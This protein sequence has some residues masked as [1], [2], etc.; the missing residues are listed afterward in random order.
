MKLYRILTSIL[1][2]VVLGAPSLVAGAG[3]VF[4]P[5]VLPESL[6]PPTLPASRPVVLVDAAA[7][8]ELRQLSDGAEVQLQVPVPDGS[9]LT[10]IVRRHRV[11]TE[12]TIIRAVTDQGIVTVPAPQS[13]HLKGTVAGHPG[14]FAMLSIFSGYAVGTISM[15]QGAEPTYH[16]SPLTTTLPSPIAVVLHADLQKPD[17][18]WCATDDLP[19]VNEVPTRKRSESTQTGSKFRIDIALECDYDYYLDHN[20]NVTTATNYAEAVIAAASAIYDRDV[21]AV[22]NI[23]SLTVFTTNDPYTG[24]TTA[25]LLTQLRNYWLGNNGTIIRTTAHL[26]SGINNIGGIAYL[27]GLC[28]TYGYAVSGLNNNIVYPRTTYAWDTDVTSHELGHNVGSRHTHSCTWN[29]PIDSCYAAEDGT[30]FTQTVAR[31]GTIM[32]YCHLTTG[33]TNLNFHP[34]VQAL[35]EDRLANYTCLAT[36]SDMT[37]TAGSDVIICYGASTT[38]SGTRSGGTAPYT[39][40]WSPTTGLS[41]TTV[42]NPTAA[43]TTTTSYI[44][45]VTDKY[46]VIRRDTVVVTVN[47]QLTA[48]LNSSYSTCSGGSVSMNLGTIGGTAPYSIRWTAANLDT[49]T[50]VGTLAYTPLSSSTLT[51]VVTDARGCTKTLTTS[52]VVHPQITATIPA[53]HQVCGGETIALTLNNV[54]GT[55]PYSIRWT[56]PS[57]DT[58]VATTTF[59]Y[60]PPEDEAVTVVVTDANACTRT[61]TTNITVHPELTPSLENQY[62]VCSGQEAILTVTNIGGTAPYTFVWTS[63]DLQQTRT[64]P[65][66]TFTPRATQTVSVAITDAKQCT[67]TI[68]TTVVVNPSPSV[69]ITGPSSKPCPN[70]EF[71]LRAGVTSAQ[72]TTTTW[73]TNNTAL[74]T[75]VSLKT[76]AP[77]STTYTA[78]TQ[79]TSGCADTAVLLVPIRATDLVPQTTSIAVPDLAACDDRFQSEVRIRNTSSDTA[80]ITSISA[81]RG[82]ASSTDLPKMIPPGGTATIPVVITLIPEALVKDTLRIEEQCGQTVRV[83]ITGQR[84]TVAVDLSNGAPAFPT[85]TLCATPVDRLIE[86]TVKNSTKSTVS[87]TAAKLKRLNSTLMIMSPTQIAATSS[88]KMTLRYRGPVTSTLQSDEIELSYAASTCTG[89]L[90]QLVD[91]PSATASLAAPLELMFDKPVSLQLEDVRID[92]T[93]RISSD[94]DW[95]ARIVDLNLAGPFRTDLQV[96]N[97]I[98]TNRDVPFTVWFQPSKMTADGSAQGQLRI[99]VDSCGWLG[100]PI[101]LQAER[102]VVSIQEDPSSAVQYRMIEKSLW[103]RA[104]QAVVSMVDA[105]GRVVLQQSFEG[106]RLFDISHVAAGVYGVTIRTSTGFV[107]RGTIICP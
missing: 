73:Y 76:A 40:A 10:L 29:P 85:R 88:L 72:P 31:T 78:I 80:M 87:I 82:N 55:A 61:V 77:Y 60:K 96:G 25:T 36:V 48:V 83:P 101:R 19:D 95:S 51:A 57:I 8:T 21:D 43:P 99:S 34:Q 7:F 66:I 33:G 71:T 6:R 105:A 97:T 75:G 23:S 63:T 106:E 15:E 84:A 16:L 56:S 37:V 22:L 50:T 54:G 14:S 64:N 24:T 3:D 93:L 107:S 39:I 67:Q 98:A 49:I 102:K 81:A 42:L 53:T 62:D 12:N 89:I 4:V 2:T 79:T 59:S 28:N 94:R 44:L 58:V 68:T 69:E 52:I 104:D 32:S 41:S 20:S 17:A 1:C 11:V 18:W 90:T 30:C 47:P 65:S 103:I 45:T 46:N 70:Q 92:T 26:F 86:V 27:N 74:G 91:M 5:H 38:L 13:V 9:S 35:M 100:E